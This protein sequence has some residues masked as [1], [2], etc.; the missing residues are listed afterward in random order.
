M[1]TR[2]ESAVFV[3]GATGFIGSHISRSLVRAGYDVH[4][5]LREYSDTWRIRDIEPRVT[6]HVGDLTD[7]EAIFRIV[8]TVNPFHILHFGGITVMSGITAPSD[9]V[10]NLNLIG[11]VNLV[12]A[13]QEIKYSS[14]INTGTFLEYGPATE[15]FR[16]GIQYGEPPEIYSITKLASTHYGQAV[17]RKEGK[18]IVTIRLFTTYGPAMAKGRVVHNVVVSALRNEPIRMTDPRITRDFAYIEDLGDLYI[19]AMSKA[20]EYRGEVF[21]ASSGRAT[22]FDELVRAVIKETNS[23]S[24]VEWGALSSVVYDSN[25]I[26]ANMEKTFAKFRWRPK[27]TLEEGL[28]KTIAWFRNNESK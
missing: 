5:L 2:V 26:Q 23:K 25:R 12:D 3:T 17:A 24:K 13:L 1:P 19:E 21:N 6:K 10:V 16:E 11:F 18:P 27:H 15:P 9:E 20:E 28:A 8:K 4:I 14:F 22:T 7:R